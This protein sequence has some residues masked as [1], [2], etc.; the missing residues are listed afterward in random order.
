MM[1]LWDTGN[2]HPSVTLDEPG[3]GSTTHLF[4]PRSLG[5]A[6]YVGPDTTVERIL[7][8]SSAKSVELVG[9]E[10]MD[11]NPTW[12]VRVQLPAP[13]STSVGLD[14]WLEAARPARVLRHSVNGDV[15]TSRYDA[16]D[17]GNPIPIEVH[18]VD[19][20]TGG[21]RI[22]SRI[23]QTR[24]DWGATVEARQFTL[25]GLGMPVGT[26]VT[27]V[28]K[29]RSMGYWTGTGLAEDPQEADGESPEA[30][31]L[32]ELMALLEFSPASD[33]ARDAAIWIVLNNP[34]G[35]EVDRAFEVLRAHHTRA[36]GLLTLCREQERVRHRGS[37]ALLEIL[38]R[39]HP[40]S[41]VRGTAC[42][43][44]G[45][46]LKDEPKFGQNAKDAAAAVQLLERAIAEFGTVRW[47]GNPLVSAALPELDDLRRLG[48]GQPAPEIAGQ[49]LGGEAMRLSDHRGRVVVL[50]FWSKGLIQANELRKLAELFRDEPFSV[51]GVFC[52]KDVEAARSEVQRRD[53]PWRSFLDGRNGP[54]GKEW[55][56]RGWPDLWVLDRQG[57]IRHRGLWDSE[58]R[59]AVERLLKE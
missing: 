26:P 38:L 20:R 48:V 17:P 54:I 22:V 40:E 53:I 7:G 55:N 35:P 4:D 21:P 37:R 32:A 34:D 41:E 10:I 36:P 39:E 57:I 16:S 33:E 14:F 47:N 46:L 6:S 58:L 8:I 18:V 2:G 50:V 28:R 25:A 23:V 52:D 59:Q 24:S 49:D 11:G 3:K 12:H 56:V 42:F 27:D 45:L 29:S 13:Q 43:A 5:L 9:Q 30:P 51:V 1:D 15:V 44:L 19:G 31:D